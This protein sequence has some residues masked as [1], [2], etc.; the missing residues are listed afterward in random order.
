MSTEQK[1]LRTTMKKLNGDSLTPI[2]IFR[3]NA[4]ASGSFCWKVPQ[5]MRDQDVIRSS[6][7]IR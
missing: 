4:R 5:S 7:W 1:G 3:K 2:L 6:E